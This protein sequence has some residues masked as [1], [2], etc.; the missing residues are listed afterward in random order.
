MVSEKSYHDR[1]QTFYRQVTPVVYIGYC[2]WCCCCC[3]TVN[4]PVPNTKHV[5]IACIA[6][7]F[8]KIDLL[9]KWTVPVWPFIVGEKLE[10][11]PIRTSNQAAGW[12]QQPRI[13]IKPVIFLVYFR[14]KPDLVVIKR[15]ELSS[16][17]LVGLSAA[18]P[19]ISRII[20]SSAAQ[21]GD[22]RSGLFFRWDISVICPIIALKLAVT[23][24][25]SLYFRTSWPNWLIF[26]R[27]FKNKFRLRTKK[28]AYERNGSEFK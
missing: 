17:G 6:G 15:V 8:V 11:F 1:S 18:V 24:F 27:S 12:E 16:T 21:Q 23:V 14:W 20:S 4:T 2:S 22:L 5:P 13:N 9:E 3:R 10:S 7:V 25:T 28:I 26:F 19:S